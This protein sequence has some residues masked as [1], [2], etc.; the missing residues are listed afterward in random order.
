MDNSHLLSDGDDYDPDDESSECDSSVNSLARELEEMESPWEFVEQTHGTG[1]DQF[2]V[3][4]SDPD[5]NDFFQKGKEEMEEE[6]INE[7]QHVRQLEA[8]HLHA[9]S[10]GLDRSNTN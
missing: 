8:G 10:L 1:S 5:L 3:L 2:T 6:L 9:D 7:Q 4:P